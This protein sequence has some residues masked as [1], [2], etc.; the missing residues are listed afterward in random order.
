VKQG[1]AAKRLR[2]SVVLGFVFFLGLLLEEDWV[3]ALGVGLLYGLG[4]F[5][6]SRYLHGG[7]DDRSDQ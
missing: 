3:A 4:Q 2:L 5:F 7:D 6:V 1:P